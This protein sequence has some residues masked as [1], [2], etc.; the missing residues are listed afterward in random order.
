MNVPQKKLHN[1]ITKKIKAQ[2]KSDVD[3]LKMII[4]GGAGWKNVYII[5]KVFRTQ[6][7]HYYGK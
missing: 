7:N 1:N 5:F 2:I 4:T 3:Q 6:I